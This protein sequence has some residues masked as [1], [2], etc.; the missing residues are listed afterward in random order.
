[1]IFK[2]NTILVDATDYSKIAKEIKNSG[3]EFILLRSL[4]SY[5]PEK[6]MNS[7][8]KEFQIYNWKKRTKF[9]GVCGE[10][11]DYDQVEGCKVC[12]KCGEKSFPF[13]F[14]AIIVSIIKDDKILLAHNTSFPDK[15]YSVIA[16][17]VD[18]GEGLEETV[19]REV[20]EE[21]GIEIKNIKYV[22]SQNWGFSSSLMVGF[23]AEYSSGDIKVDGEEIDRADWFSIDSLPELPPNISIARKLINRFIDRLNAG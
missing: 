15:M 9:C 4:A 1:M 14:P 13:L 20:K 22:S 10:L 11:N 23:T 17:F 3:Q 18:I 19:I 5:I 7:I 2:D 12:P 8:L 16:G 21:V 6:E